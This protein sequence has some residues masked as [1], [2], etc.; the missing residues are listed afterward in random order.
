MFTLNFITIKLA[1]FINKNVLYFRKES[2]FFVIYLKK[3]IK[4]LKASVE[5]KDLLSAGFNKLR[6]D[7][8]F[9]RLL[10]LC[11]KDLAAFDRDATFWS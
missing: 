11:V 6:F 9:G 2:I 1:S 4:L 3:N 10:G 7:Q 8:Q 5:G